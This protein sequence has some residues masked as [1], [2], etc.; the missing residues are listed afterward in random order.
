MVWLNLRNVD[1]WS[2][3]DG[4]SG[5]SGG[6]SQFPS[7]LSG[8]SVRP[9]WQVSGVDYGVGLKSNVS[10]DTSSDV[11]TITG[12]QNNHINGQKV[13]FRTANGGTLPGGI[14]SD[15]AYFVVNVSGNTFKVSTTSGGAAIDLTGSPDN[16]VVLKIP[17]AGA[18]SMPPGVVYTSGQS[19]TGSSLESV[20]PTGASDTSNGNQSAVGTINIDSYDFSFDS[21]GTNQ[22]GISIQTGGFN[23]TVNVKNCYFKTGD[24]LQCWIWQN[25]TASDTYNLTYNEFDGGGLLQF[26]NLLRNLQHGLY[27]IPGGTWQYNWF[28]HTVAPIIASPS[29]TYTMQYNLVSNHHYGQQASH[30]DGIFPSVASNISNSIQSWNCFYQPT[31]SVFGNG[32]GY[33][34]ECDTSFFIFLQ[35]NNSLTLTGIKANNNTVI[36]LGSSGH[37]NTTTQAGGPAF[38]IGWDIEPKVGNTISGMEIKDNYVDSTGIETSASFGII[39][40][41]AGAGTVSGSVISGNISLNTGNTITANT[42]GIQ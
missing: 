38:A 37:M 19:H 5:A 32:N 3:Q 28:H 10:V 12:T 34:G 9:P 35:P 11:I 18:N 24:W 39:K 40:N 36:G 2:S 4:R 6:T 7:I 8:Y 30:V 1:T 14:S 23:G 41:N 31:A 26:G 17:V 16:V 22:H 27:N 29:S 21:T 33:P 13:C 15:T 42:S 25:T 20:A